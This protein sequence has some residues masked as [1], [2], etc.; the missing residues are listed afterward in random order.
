M[1]SWVGEHSAPAAQVPDS[2]GITSDDSGRI[3]GDA[4]RVPGDPAGR[5]HR[6]SGDV[7]RTQ[8]RHPWSPGFERRPFRRRLVAAGY[9]VATRVVSWAQVG[10]GVL[11]VAAVAPK[12]APRSASAIP[13]TT[14]N[15]VE[16]TEPASV[17]AATRPTGRH[18]GCPNRIRRHVTGG[19]G[20]H[21]R[22]HVVAACSTSR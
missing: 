1:A 8:S 7:L 2:A 20:C 5:R 18:L 4:A 10:L 9:P 19:L 13:P 17:P 15:G 11:R 6:D 16:S 12:A 14:T 21:R 22:R 3:R